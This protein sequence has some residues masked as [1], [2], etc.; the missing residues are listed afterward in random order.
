MKK[1]LISLVLLSICFS[2]AQ[3]T[4][5]ERGYISVS[6]TANTEVVP[7][8]AEI[9][10]SV[11]TFDNKSMQKATQ[12]NSEIS[13]KIISELKSMINNSN[14]DYIKTSN[15]SASP[16]YTYNGGK[17]SFDKYQVSNTVVIHTKSIDKVGIMIDKSIN[18]G[19]T[20]ISSLVFSISN[21]ENQCNDLLELAAKRS[22]D[23]INSVAK[24]TSTSISGI[25]TMDLSCSA[26]N[27]YRP[28]YRLLKANL[29]T[30]TASETS[31]TTIE[32][33]V[34]KIFATVN[35][36]YFVK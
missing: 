4:D 16:I 1:L 14:G 11:Q 26:N 30:D 22:K 2:C 24:V 13:D 5:I 10:V 31:S 21:Y 19:A 23:R 17:K 33:G 34:I 27:S 12:L 29:A 3:A 18:L 7:D 8:I 28:Q 36:S 15:F 35:A 32:N 25:R 9:S 20:N 6:T